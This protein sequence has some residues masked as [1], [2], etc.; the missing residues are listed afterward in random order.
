[1]A[2]II[3]CLYF[4]TQFSSKRWLA[5]LYILCGTLDGS[6]HLWVLNIFILK[7]EIMLL[8]Q[9]FSISTLNQNPQLQSRL[10]GW[11]MGGSVVNMQQGPE[12]S[13]S[14]HPQH[15]MFSYW[16]FL[17][18]SFI[19]KYILKHWTLRSYLAQNSLNLIHSIVG[20]KLSNCC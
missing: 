19:A 6:L 8:D 10:R 1:M 9:W 2:L 5:W 13:S 14:L 3:C 11:G 20:L 15:L 4:H 17:W 18:D 12:Q 16:I 7:I